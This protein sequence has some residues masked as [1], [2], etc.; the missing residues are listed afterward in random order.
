M[1][2][3]A[4]TTSAIVNPEQW[5]TSSQN[6]RLEGSQHAA[7]FVSIDIQN[8]HAKRLEQMMRTASPTPSLAASTPPPSR[9]P[10]QV[11]VSE[12]LVKGWKNFFHYAGLATGALAIPTLALAIISPVFLAIPAG[13]FVIS[14][15]CF[16]LRGKETPEIKAAHVEMQRQNRMFDSQSI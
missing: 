16:F 10:S 9:Q 14:L 8:I 5:E 4:A 11:F 13:L 2:I 3:Q 7:Q 1:K 15:A 6:A 12:K